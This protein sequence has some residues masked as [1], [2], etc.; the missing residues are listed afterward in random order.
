MTYKEG[1][2]G[3]GGRG[4]G[5]GGDCQGGHGQLYCTNET[6]TDKRLVTTCAH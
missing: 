4:G 3:E 1:V 5:G 2:V 6:K